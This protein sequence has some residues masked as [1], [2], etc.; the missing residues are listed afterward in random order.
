MLVPQIKPTK[1]IRYQNY[2]LALSIRKTIEFI[3]QIVFLDLPP[4]IRRKFG[5]KKF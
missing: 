1:Q 5:K 2:E 3:G 4:R